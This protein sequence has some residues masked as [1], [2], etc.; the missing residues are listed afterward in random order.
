MD[1]SLPQL[2]AL[3]PA[4]GFLLAAVPVNAAI[5]HNPRTGEAPLPVECP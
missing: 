4:N 2:N 5:I 1:R 3:L